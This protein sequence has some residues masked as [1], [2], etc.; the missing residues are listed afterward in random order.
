MDYTMGAQRRRLVNPAKMAS[1]PKPRHLFSHLHSPTDSQHFAILA[2]FLI[3][4]LY[5]DL[6]HW[7]SM[8][9]KRNFQFKISVFGQKP[10]IKVLLIQELRI[11]ALSAL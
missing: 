5:L 7:R 1:L 10:A 4:Q 11:E 3:S 8:D 9:V 2:I 6:T